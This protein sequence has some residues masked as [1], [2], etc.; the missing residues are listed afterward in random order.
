[1]AITPIA[2]MISND[3]NLVL[4]GPAGIEIMSAIGSG[5]FSG[6]CLGG[7][8]DAANAL[9]GGSADYRMRDFA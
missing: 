8:Y 2:S 5:W 9:V 4:D 1:V 3:G 7:G 6:Q